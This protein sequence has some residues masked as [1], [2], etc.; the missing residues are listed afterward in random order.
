MSNEKTNGGYGYT[1]Q[2]QKESAF[3]FG[4]SPGAATLTKFAWTPNGGK[5]GTER[6]ALDIVF[7]IGDREV[8]YRKF[9]ITKAY[10]KPEGGGPQQETTDSEHPAFKQEQS[11][12]SA[13]L[14]HIVGCYI[15]KE[16]IKTALQRPIQNFKDYCSVLQGL[17]P[18]DFA[19]KSLDLFFQWQWQIKGDNEKT[20]LEL[21]KNMKHGRWIGP[22]L[23]A[24]GEWEQQTK[25][26][27][28]DNQTALRFVDKDGNIHPFVRNGWFMNSNFATQ[29]KEQESTAGANIAGKAAAGGG[30]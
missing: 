10:F 7:K 30:W 6:E 3:G 25:L 4:L 14:V 11:N 9:P 22:A 5:G 26:D 17:L 21:P 2:E 27:A 24:N 15:P 16:D 18:T 19:N 20:F 8:S 29:Q 28:S 12:L 13:V 23:A 1:E